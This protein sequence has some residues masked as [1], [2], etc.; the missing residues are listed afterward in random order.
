[1]D[2]FCVSVHCGAS[3]KQSWWSLLWVVMA[4][5][6]CSCTS[7]PHSQAPR[8]GASPAPPVLTIEQTIQLFPPGV[9]D[10]GGWAHD[11]FYGLQEHHLE[12]RPWAVCATLALIE[13][14]SN[15]TL[16]PAVPGLARIAAQQ[17]DA[18]FSRLGSLGPTVRRWL[19]QGKAA[20]SPFTFEA[21]LQQ[22]KTEGDIDRWYRDLLQYYR[23]ESVRA[24]LP[25]PLATQLEELIEEENR[26]TTVGP[27]QVKVR[28]AREVAKERGENPDTVRDVLYTRR[29]GLSYGIAQFLGYQSHYALPRY[30]FADY[31]AGRYSSRN[32]AVQEQLSYLTGFSLIPDG[33]LL[34]YDQRGQPTAVASQ[35]LQALVQFRHTYVPWLREA[36]L[37]R[38][39]QVEKT[40]AFEETA[41]YRAIKKVYQQVT[42]RPPAYAR[43]PEVRIHSVKMRHTHDED[44]LSTR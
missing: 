17:A 26:V 4:V 11:I 20:G 37:R 32:A 28:F 10:R 22:V 43:V 44:W 7:P 3:A 8:S 38:D 41:T 31:N 29:G 25:T 34:Q 33:D 16:D 15:F 39:V 42:G 9:K 19:L 18:L 30:R 1:M 24:W 13:Q 6:A 35:S 40:F 5:L 14:E 12:P 2:V 36:Q 21:R 23:M 27:M